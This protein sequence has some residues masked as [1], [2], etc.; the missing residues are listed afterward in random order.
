[1]VSSVSYHTASH[2][3]TM[4]P[5]DSSACISPRPPEAVPSSP[6]SAP[7]DDDIPA[8]FRYIP[9][10]PE[11]NEASLGEHMSYDWA[12]AAELL[13]DFANERALNVEWLDKCRTDERALF[14]LAD[15][16]VGCACN[17]R[18]T[19]L[20]EAS[21]RLMHLGS[22]LQRGEYSSEEGWVQR[23]K[24]ALID[25]CVVEHDRVIAL[26]PYFDEKADVEREAQE[27]EERA[28]RDEALLD[29]MWRTPPAA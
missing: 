12:F 26:L 19:A 14:Q 16:I 8:D 3:I 4:Q 9:G 18:L 21:D 1:M 6:S 17:L 7:S 22:A 23:A 2:T 24:A 13:H 28:R 11:V 29:E 20:A 25:G 10:L 5:L 15:R 27:E